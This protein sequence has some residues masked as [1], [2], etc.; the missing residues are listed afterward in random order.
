MTPDHR[1]MMLYCLHGG[2]TIIH[3]TGWDNSKLIT[4][5]QYTNTKIKTA[6]RSSAQSDQVDYWSNNIAHT[7]SLTLL[8]M[9]AQSPHIPT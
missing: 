2:E 6:S 7:Q 4:A 9:V 3:S 1:G 5:L 8:D